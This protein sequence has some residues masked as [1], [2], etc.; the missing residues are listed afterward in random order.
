M[1]AFSLNR[2]RSE[3]ERLNEHKSACWWVDEQGNK[4]GVFL[5]KLL[6]PNQFHWEREWGERGGEGHDQVRRKDTCGKVQECQKPLQGKWLYNHKG[7]TNVFSKIILPKFFIFSFFYII[8]H[9]QPPMPTQW[10]SA[11]SREV[12][13]QTPING[14]CHYPIPAGRSPYRK[15]NMGRIM[16][17]IL[18]IS[19]KDPA[20]IVPGSLKPR[21]VE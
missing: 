13:D 2:C 18:C 4:L 7:S 20:G 14:I 16:H 3:D 19:C 11:Q 17:D 21:E 9:L 8:V 10:L 12:M 5:S 15:W 1:W 6:L